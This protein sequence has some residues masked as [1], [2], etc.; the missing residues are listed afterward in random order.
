MRIYE[1]FWEFLKS[2]GRAKRRGRNPKKSF[3]DLCRLAKG[4]REA[5]P[6]AQRSGGKWRC[7]IGPEGGGPD[8]GRFH[9]CRS[10]G[11]KRTSGRIGPII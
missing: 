1:N 9:P 2:S 6:R 8:L 4:G 7:K 10:G 5:G 3:R 11:S